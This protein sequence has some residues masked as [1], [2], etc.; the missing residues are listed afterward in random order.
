MSRPQRHR[1][2][3]GYPMAPL[4]WPVRGRYEPF[5]EIKL[6]PSRPLIIG[7]LPHT[8]CNPK[9]RG[10]G[11]C[12]FPHEKFGREPLRR[13]VDEVANEI[14]WI[15]M[16][17]PELRARH[18]EAVY[19]GGGTANLTPPDDL[20]RLCSI[21]GC[22][23]D[24]SGS[25]LTLEGVPRYF[26]LQDE[27]LLDVLAE[28]G[29]RHR[30]ISMGVQ[31][32]DP[33]WLRRMGR[34]AFGDRSEIQRVVDAAH[35]RGFT[36][37]ADL[38]FNLPG[39]SRDLVLA[40]VHTAV[41]LGFDQICAYNLVLTPD[42][43]TEW[44]RESSLVQSM[45]Q[46]E[47]ALATWLAVRERLLASGYVQTTLTN[48]ERADIVGTSRRFVYEAASFDPARYDGIGFGPGA[49]ST[50]TSRDPH[51]ALKWMNT[52]TSN[53]FI[54]AI[55]KLGLATAS[56][57]PYDETDLRLLH[58]T[59]NLARLSI[60]RAAYEAYFGTDPLTD[61]AP[62]WQALEEA[63]LVRLDGP[64]RIEPTPEGMFYADAIAGLL[65]HEQAGE[66]KRL[67]G[68]RAGSRRHLEQHMG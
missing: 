60:D 53:D 67:I 9:I 63:R 21:L 66:L 20:R 39:A 37:S 42:L 25:E 33:G 46:V 65:A 30:R 4:M 35:R 59:R 64:A 5:A 23:F 10:C 62:H 6:D 18:V 40:D 43:G 61:F 47:E 13:T 8:F 22:T 44:A 51:S 1:L 56:V 17:E 52:G 45:P 55:D 54:S 48:F 31:T 32:F 12:T 49:I 7:V 58:L 26:L 29:V 57:F 24:L 68:D 38:L 16:R 36:A 14:E 28:A 3:Q 34:D 27:A 2:L 11:F 41:E 15:E 19:F 50:F